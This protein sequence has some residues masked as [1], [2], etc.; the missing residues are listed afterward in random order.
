MGEKAS[1]RLV[2]NL[3]LAATVAVPIFCYVQNNWLQ[4][5]NINY[6]SAKLP[7]GF[8]GF[9][10]VHISDLHNKEFGKNQQGLIEKIKEFS[11]DIIA[12]T[13]DLIDRRITKLGIALE[14]IIRAKKI[15]PVYY[16]TGNHEKRSRDYTILKRE[17][18]NQDVRIMDDTS[19]ILEYNGDH[20]QI[21]GLG[22]PILLEYFSDKPY[23][24]EVEQTINRLKKDHQEYFTLLLSHRP[25]YFDI[26]AN[27]NIDLTLSGHV[28]GGQVRLPVIGGLY[29]P[30]QGILPKYT[31][32]IYKKENS[33]LLIS[34]GL[35]NTSRCPVRVFNRP[36]LVNITLNSI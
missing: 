30:G 16:V 27:Q 21:M 28:H 11:P 5:S 22:D 25:E 24:E 10:I 29:A 33:T 19:K 18:I 15:A 20:I 3:G 7:K 32:G 14:F 23:G 17:L 12:V 13:G 26:Y 6:S 4:I 9:K 34:R 2:K 1:N 36:N 35:G 8:N 31:G